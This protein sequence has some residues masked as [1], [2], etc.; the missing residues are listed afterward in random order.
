MKFSAKHRH[1]RHRFKATVMGLRVPS[2]MSGAGEPGGS[3]GSAKQG[4]AGHS[5]R[6]NTAGAAQ[7]GD[8][9]SSEPE[10]EPGRGS[11][12]LERAF[13]GAF[14]ANFGS[15]RPVPPSEAGDGRQQSKLAA[16]A[17]RG[18]QHPVRATG[19]RPSGRRQTRITAPPLRADAA[20]AQ[21]ARGADRPGA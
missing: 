15:E 5:N 7:T 8:D 19:A 11:R 10:P 17:N 4:C 1:A 6:T 21:S 9:G 14:G 12:R 2:L 3:G 18:R 20:T 16:G 13:G